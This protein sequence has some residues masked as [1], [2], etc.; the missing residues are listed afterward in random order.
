MP[1]VTDRHGASR[2]RDPASG[3]TS[4][5]RARRSVTSERVPDEAAR[6]FAASRARALLANADGG[7]ILARLADEPRVC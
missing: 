4:V 2:A 1:A 5:I 6:R 7:S 3:E